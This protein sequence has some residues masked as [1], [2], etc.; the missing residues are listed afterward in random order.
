MKLV[1]V[2]SCLACTFFLLGEEGRGWN[3]QITLSSCSTCWRPRSHS[4]SVHSLSQTPFR[5]PDQMSCSAAWQTPLLFLPAQP[6]ALLKN[7]QVKSWGKRINLWRCQFSLLT[8]STPHT[9]T[10]PDVSIH[11]TE[12]CGRHKDRTTR[13]VHTKRQE[14]H[15]TEDAQ[16]H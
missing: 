5:H 2:L 11:Q 14:P 3:S 13:T 15:A 6:R 10:K 8:P 1:D 16:N 7:P 9:T 4:R 12:S